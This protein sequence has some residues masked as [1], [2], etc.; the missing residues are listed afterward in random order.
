MS[1]RRFLLTV[2]TNLPIATVGLQIVP[3]AAEV[4]ALGQRLRGI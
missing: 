2:G 1:Q 3:T 4:V